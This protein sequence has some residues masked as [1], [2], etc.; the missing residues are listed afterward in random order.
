MRKWENGK[1][2]DLLPITGLNR[3]LFVEYLTESGGFPDGIVAAG[4]RIARRGGRAV[5]YEDAGAKRTQ[6]MAL[7][8]TV[9][10][11]GGAIFYAVA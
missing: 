6:L 1:G 4:E 3:C 5:E 8:M 9:A 10:V 11:V 2:P 7:L